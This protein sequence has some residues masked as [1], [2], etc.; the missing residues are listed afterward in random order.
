MHRR[1]G[2]NP[3][4]SRHFAPSA[5]RLCFFRTAAVPKKGHKADRRILHL[6]FEL[7]FSAKQRIC[8]A[9]PQFRRAVKRER[10]LASPA[11][12]IPACGQQFCFA[13]HRRPQFHTREGLYRCQAAVIR[14]KNDSLHQHFAVLP[15]DQLRFRFAKPQSQK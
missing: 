2:R 13:Q 7:S 3:A 14:L 11:F 6:R 4:P 1:C 5:Q 10:N 15:P 8:T 12:C 9:R